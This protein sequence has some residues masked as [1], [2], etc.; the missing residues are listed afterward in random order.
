MTGAIKLKRRGWTTIYTIGRKNWLFSAT[1]E[2]ASASANLYSLVE[3]AR[4]NGLDPFEY[5]K[6]VFEKL[7]CADNEKLLLELLPIKA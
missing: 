7:P 1:P 5:L 3:T 4:A 6:N 2:G